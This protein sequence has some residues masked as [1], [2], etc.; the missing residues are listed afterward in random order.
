MHI[1]MD[2][3][4]DLDLFGPVVD[5]VRAMEVYLNSPRVNSVG[6]DCF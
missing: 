5:S 2:F 4:N 1:T 3:S 6:V